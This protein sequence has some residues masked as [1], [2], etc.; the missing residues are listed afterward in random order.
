MLCSHLRSDDHDKTDRRLQRSKGFE[1]AKQSAKSFYFYVYGRSTVQ[2]A[3]AHSLLNMYT[4][5]HGISPK[6]LISMFINIIAWD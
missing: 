5:G 2:F 3:S 6:P 1:A 4:L